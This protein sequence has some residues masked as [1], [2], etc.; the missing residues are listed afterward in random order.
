MNNNKQNVH[1]ISSISNDEND[2]FSI[3][4]QGKLFPVFQPIVNLSC[5]KI[6]AYEALIRGPVDSPFF[7]PS[8]LFE[9]AKVLNHVEELERKCVDIACNVFKTSNSEKKLFINIS[10]LCLVLGDTEKFIA[11]LLFEKFKFNPEQVVI[12]ISEQ[13]PIEDYEIIRASLNYYRNLGLKIAIDDLG[14]GYSGLRFWSEIKP[15]YV[16]IDRH[17]INNINTDP[18]KRE[19]VKS[20]QEIS[21]GLNC[22]VIA[23]GIETEEE[24]AT[25]QI[26][27]IS[28]AQGFLLGKPEK[29]PALKLHPAVKNGFNLAL[30]SKQ[31]INDTIESLVEQRL[32]VN[33]DCKLEIVADL[34]NKDKQLFSLPV[35][36]NERP[37]GIVIRHNILELFLTRY[38]RE[39]Y[40][41]KPIKDFMNTSPIIVEKDNDLKSVSKMITHEDNQ[42]LNTAFIV[43]NNNK[44]IGIGR[45]KKLLQQITEEQIH[46]ARYANPLTLLPGN[47]P[48]YEWIDELIK[49]KQKFHI[50]YCDLNFFK[51]YNDKYGYSKGDEIIT[52]LGELLKSELTSRTDRVGH[53]G[54]DD[55]VILFTNDDWKSVCE[56]ILNFFAKQV[57]YFYKADD[58]KAGG[59]NGISR[60]GKEEFFPILS[61]AIGVVSPNPKLCSSHHD[62]AELASDAKHEAKK[63][64]GNS[65]FVSRRRAPSKQL[66]HKPISRTT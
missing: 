17:F 31:N 27:G 37:I 6:D 25:I 63:L 58:I 4:N 29:K 7:H 5:S 35:V 44:Y 60:T 54:G 36:E 23:E 40:S 57:T 3:I 33:S 32:P 38:G 42:E 11:H 28:H 47:V 16:K 59:I 12:E 49:Q 24:L 21:S 56:N 52:W 51:P 55:F 66:E 34:F 18:I 61:L 8:K 9:T 50:A 13:Y 30:N 14:A 62:V 39:L 45:T 53:I 2:F 22:H 19:F 10:P 26:I 48:I 15:D 41:K 20:I 43:T 64:G 46:N 1:N 65:L